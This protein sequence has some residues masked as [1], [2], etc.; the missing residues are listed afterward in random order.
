MTVVK[1][2]DILY[3]DPS[4]LKNLPK[5]MTLQ[6]D[7][8]S[9][10]ETTG[11]NTYYSSY[12][13]E[14][15]RDY[16]ELKLTKEHHVDSI[17]KGGTLSS[18]THQKLLSV[19]LRDTCE[20]YGFHIP[21]QKEPLLALCYNITNQI[22][23]EVTK[24][25]E[26][27]VSSLDYLDFIEA[28][29]NKKILGAIETMTKDADGIN[30]VYAVV[31]QVLT[32]DED[33]KHNRIASSV[34]G[35]LMKFGQICQC[36]SVRGFQY[37]V[38]GSIMTVPIMSNY[39]RGLNNLYEFAAESR[40]AARH[41]YFSEAP[42]Q[43]AEYFA[44][45]LQLMCMS[46]ERIEYTDCGSTDYLEW[47]VSGPI[48]DDVGKL[49]FKGDLGFMLGKYYLDESSGML[50]EITGDD[51][52]LHNTVLKLRS[53]L[54]CKH[55]NPHVVCS[56]CF[57]ALAKN[58]SR[59][60]NIGHLCAAMMTHQTS[61][62]VLSTKHL[63]ASGE[64]SEI[65]LNEFSSKFLT[66][67]KRK[68]VY[69]LRRDL[70]DLITHVSISPEQAV[71]LT[72]IYQLKDIEDINPSRVS[73]ISHMEVHVTNPNGS[74]FTYQM[75]VSQRTH[76]AVL[77]T[78][79]LRYLRE[80]SWQVDE[81]GHFLFNLKDWDF[82]QAIMY[83]P[84]MEYSYSDHSDQIALAI[85]SRVEDIKKRSRPNSRV[86]TLQELHSLV[87]SKLNVNLVCLEAIIYT[88]SI[89]NQFDHDMSRGYDNP[90]LGVANS[91]NRNRS[92]GTAYAFQDHLKTITSPESFFKL[93]RPSSIFDVFVAPRE[94]VAEEK[95]R[96]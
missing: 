13:W 32:E 87:N 51:P 48:Y 84:A 15:H 25:A 83:M 72:E 91:I 4:Q 1:A 41:Y 45:R 66:T 75:N 39:T 10:I 44:R 73:S 30:K 86:A 50:K 19:L 36:I 24:D 69:I 42:L 3:L 12:F 94:V 55:P 59:F 43:D 70:Q 22:Y 63:V 37:E 35:G 58:V 62:S 40:G 54:T 49:L 27:D 77:T 88:A 76:K 96:G 18:S 23:N 28:A 17:L 14:F 33:F 38:E 61:Q 68:N 85:E 82:E 52:S 21:V 81:R 6:F 65:I 56:T 78:T 29:S 74:I 31:K 34:T 90:I 26:A 92:L 5:V 20:L 79:F 2:S 53:P 8:G 93:N 80:K 7:D 16:S 9:F 95:A 57:G 71:G 11:K 89:P 46:L 67:N 47:L 64:G 60:A